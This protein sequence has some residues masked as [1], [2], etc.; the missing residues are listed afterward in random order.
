MTRIWWIST[1]TLKIVK[2]SILINSFCAKY[3]TLELKKYRG[4][5]FHDIEEWCKIWRKTDL[6]F[7]KWHEEYGKFSPEHSMD[8][9]I[10]SKKCMSLKFTEKLSIMTLKN[11]AQ[12]GRRFTCCF[13]IEMRNLTNFE[14]STQMSQMAISD[15]NI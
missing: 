12:F 10:Q 1:W 3:I 6:W 4:V 5:M 8:L 13:K 2:I 9:F 14:P 15:Q 11:N 7:G